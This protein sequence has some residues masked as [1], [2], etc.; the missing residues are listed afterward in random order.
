MCEIGRLNEEWYLFFLGRVFVFICGLKERGFVRGTRGG[1]L[2]FVVEK[3]ASLE[4][5]FEEE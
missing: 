2:L 1:W 4:W 5:D 3:V